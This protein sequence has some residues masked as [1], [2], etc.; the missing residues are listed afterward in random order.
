MRKVSYIFKKIVFQKLW[1]TER[2]TQHGATRLITANCSVCCATNLK[3]LFES[4][5]AHF[6]IGFWNF[7]FVSERKKWC[8]WVQQNV[9]VMYFLMTCW[10]GASN[11]W[12]SPSDLHDNCILSTCWFVF[13]FLIIIKF[14]TIFFIYINYLLILLFFTFYF[15]NFKTLK[16]V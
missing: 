7:V 4:L 3:R 5:R 11:I 16:T 12:P 13:M 2:K 14:K 9:C 15:T 1:L 8:R 6:F 10:I